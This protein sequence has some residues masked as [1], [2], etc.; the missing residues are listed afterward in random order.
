MIGI[1]PY[2][3]PEC[4]SNSECA[5]HLACQ[6]QKCQDP[7][8]GSCGYKALCKTVNHIP[9]CHC[10]EGYTG[11][12]FSYCHKTPSRFFIFFS[13]YKNINKNSLAT[14]STPVIHYEQ[15]IIPQPEVPATIPNPCQPSPCGANAICSNKNGVASCSCLPEF[16]GSAPNCRPECISNSECASHL[17]CINRKCQDP[18]P[19]LC[20]LNAECRTYNHVP[21]CICIN[22]YTGDPYAGCQAPIVIKDIPQIHHEL[23]VP[24]IPNP[25]GSNA[26]CIAENRA[27]TCVC[28]PKYYGNPYLACRPECV[29]NSD[30]PSHRACVQNKCIDPCPG[31]CGINTQC[32]VNNHIPHCQCL[33]NYVG[34]PYQICSAPVQKSK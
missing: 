28:L 4:T 29:I 2:C 23:T 8:P 1:A 31:T 25:C 27:S 34:N 13:N 19:G 7:C 16:I 22:G 20:G 30:C 3:R 6:N 32:F 5:L 26:R 9:Q 14:P 33:Y 10:L 11:S 18:C 15:P 12:P 21:N 24:C 17:A